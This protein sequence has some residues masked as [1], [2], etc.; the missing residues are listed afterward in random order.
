MMPG[1]DE[2]HEMSCMEIWGGNR[3]IDDAISTPGI[4]AWVYSRPHAGGERGG[5]VHYVSM[6]AAG[7]IARFAVADVS[8]HGETVSA[9]AAALRALMKRHINTPDQTKLTRALNDGFSRSGLGG[10][11]ATA[12]LASYFAP[13]DH[14]ILCNA[15]HPRP[16]WWRASERRWEVLDH[17][18]D[19]AATDG[20]VAN[21]PLG[22]IE[23]TAYHQFAVRLG[24]GDRV[25]LYT[26]SLVEARNASGEML[27][28]TGLLDLATEVARE[29]EELDDPHLVR[30][31]VSRVRAYTGD[32]EPEDDVTAMLL[33]HNGGDP[34]RQSLGEKIRVLGKMMGL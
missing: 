24:V 3:A 11:F 18:A 28:E 26:D 27:G 33:T 8:G 19:A 9:F 21:L 1:E 31:L 14:L 4:D 7:K 6:C 12:V 20:G 22:V 13:T 17:E 2:T 23:P 30:R 10:L 16:L 5:D 32:A 15:G 34:A 25:L 29:S